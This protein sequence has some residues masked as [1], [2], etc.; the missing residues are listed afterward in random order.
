MS[1]YLSF[2]FIGSRR[3]SRWSQ[4]G[5]YS[6][7]RAKGVLIFSWG[8]CANSYRSARVLSVGREGAVACS[9]S[10]AKLRSGKRSAC[11]RSC[12]SLHATDSPS[13]C[14]G[15]CP[16]HSS[17]SARSRP[18][19]TAWAA[20]RRHLCREREGSSG[21]VGGLTSRLVGLTSGRFTPLMRV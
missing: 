5:I 4:L 13:S 20:R 9:L 3:F 12:T 10:P 15:S 1:F 17:T 8:Y 11:R 14:R 6:A 21:R 18:Y 2:V 19:R 16:P 7:L